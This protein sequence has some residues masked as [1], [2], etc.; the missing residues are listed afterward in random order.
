MSIL[1]QQYNKFLARHDK[2]VAYLEDEK[3]PLYERMKWLPEHRKLCQQLGA[4][5]VEI[6]EY[7]NIEALEGFDVQDK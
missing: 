7:T 2:A 4:M 3:I 6:G 1:K 5:L